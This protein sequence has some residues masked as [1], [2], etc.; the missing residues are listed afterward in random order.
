MSSI[1]KTYLNYLAQ[2][3]SL[4]P[5]DLDQLRALTERHRYLQSA[6]ALRWLN[7]TDQKEKAKALSRAAALTYDRMILVRLQRNP[8]LVI[9]QDSLDENELEE[10]APLENKVVQHMNTVRSDFDKSLEDLRVTPRIPVPDL[11]DKL[12]FEIEGHIEPATTDRPTA[13]TQKTFADWMKLMVSGNTEGL[14]EHPIENSDK[15]RKFDLLDKF[16]Q[17]KPKIK[18]DPDHEPDFELDDS[19]YFD[20][21]EM[22]TETLAQLLLDQKKYRKAIKAYKALMVKIPEKSSFFADQIKKAKALKAKE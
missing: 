4:L 15:R 8:S 19:I 6:W 10:G 21:E 3:T 2:P 1:A 14:L 17:E 5:Q 18:A 22:I 13:S 16:I 11:A 9:G 20:Y 12:D 7:A